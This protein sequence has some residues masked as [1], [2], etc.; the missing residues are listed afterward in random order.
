MTDRSTFSEIYV[1]QESV[2]R[3]YQIF[4]NVLQGISIPF[5]FSRGISG[6]FGQIVRISAIG[7]FWGCPE[8][9]EGHFHAIHPHFESSAI[10]GGIESAQGHK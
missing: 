3:V 9:F 10:F 7:Q 6:N 1:K 2:A 4:E 8:T 5:E